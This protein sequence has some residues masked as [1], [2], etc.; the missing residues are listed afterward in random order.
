MHGSD[1]KLYVY[2]Y[3]EVISCFQVCLNDDPTFVD[4]DRP[5][6]NVKCAY[7]IGLNGII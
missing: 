5:N 3:M 1:S 7:L 2:I 6:F 4:L